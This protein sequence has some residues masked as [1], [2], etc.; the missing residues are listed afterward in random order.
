ML[1]N[2]YLSL[3]SFVLVCIELLMP[4]GFDKEGDWAS[5]CFAVMSSHDSMN[6]VFK[7]LSKG[8]VDFLVKPVRKNELKNLWQHVWRRCTSV[9]ENWHTNIGWYKGTEE[10]SMWFFVFCMMCVSQFKQRAAVYSVNLN[11]LYQ[12]LI[13]SLWRRLFVRVPEACSRSSHGVWAYSWWRPYCI[14]AVFYALPLLCWKPLVSSL[15]T[16]WAWYGF[17]AISAWGYQLSL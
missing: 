16:S 12:L 2:I 7:C 15:C 4:E 17:H 6:V 3:V 11:C 9:S 8:A 1:S 5:F 14:I 10:L 13:E